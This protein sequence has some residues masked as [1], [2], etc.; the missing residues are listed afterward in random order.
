M[1]CGTGGGDRSLICR[2]A[3]VGEQR[4]APLAQFNRRQNPRPLSFRQ[5]LVQQGI[6]EV[7]LPGI[8]VRQEVFEAGLPVQQRQDACRCCGSGT[9]GQ[10]IQHRFKFIQRPV[11]FLVLETEEL[12]LPAF[13]RG[14]H[15]LFIGREDMGFFIGDVLAEQR[16]VVRQM[17]GGGRQIAI[18]QGSLMLKKDSIHPGM[19][20]EEAAQG[21]GQFMRHAPSESQTSESSVLLRTTSQQARTMPPMPTSQLSTNADRLVALSV[22]GKVAEPALSAAFGVGSDGTARSLPGIGGICFNVKVGDSCF[23]WEGDHIEPCVSAILDR[24]NRMSP[25]NRGFHAYPCVGNEVRVMSGDAKGA[26][27]MVTGQHGGAEHVIIDFADDV[28][29]VLSHED[30]LRITAFGMGL[31]LL[32]YPQIVCHNLSPTFLERM[33]IEA[34][35]DEGITVGVV[36]NIPGF[37]M[38]SGIGSVSPMMGDYDIMTT[39][40]AMV[41]KYRLDTLRLG[42]LVAIINH[43]NSFGRHY[44]EGA[45]TIG[46]ITHSNS[47]AAGHGP[48]VV[49]LM[50]SRLPVI[51]T[52]YDPDANI[53]R[54]F[55]IGRQ[56]PGAG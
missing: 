27:G 47:Y 8:V 18:K 50:T 24:E 10:L 46:I 45:T 29:E 3:S 40:P 1:K 12:G 2:H 39:D 53:A 31:K 30:R 42:D 15:R 28:L 25:R 44:Y 16:R 23:G 33:N 34:D 56:R 32:N 7:P 54:F 11:E 37:L 55:A 5:M 26:H 41:A 38:G 22:E 14:L 52:A 13:R 20:V 4:A 19:E 21:R 51:R 48:G 49:A 17:A 36:A 9:L 35:D 6:E 43:D